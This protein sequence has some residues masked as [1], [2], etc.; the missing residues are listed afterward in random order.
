MNQHNFDP[1]LQALEFLGKYHGRSIN[2]DSA[3][4]GLPTVDG[5][6]TPELFERAAKRSGFTS[7]IANRPLK[8]IH[9]ATLPVVLLLENGE[10]V[11]LLGFKSKRV[12][13]CAVLSA[14]GGTQAIKLKEL[15]KF[16]SG[17]AIFAKPA[18][19][20]EERSEFAPTQ[21][22]KNWFWG[23]LW[24]FR[25]FYG[26]VG[27]ATV[28]IN[29]LALAS[30]LFIMNVYDRVVP[31]QAVDTLYALAIGA[32]AAFVLEFALK[33]LR[34]YLVDRAGHRIDLILGG[35]LFGK[36]LGMKYA[37]KPTS[38]GT[39]A[40]QARSY[41]GLREF[42]TSASISALFDLPFVF[43]FAGVVFVLGG[44]A[45][46]PLFCGA[47]FALVFAALMQVPISRA[48]SSSYAAGNQRQALY[49]EGVTALETIKSTC[50]ESELQAR[51]E[52]SVHVSA[53]ADGK[54]RGF[55]QLALNMTSFTQQIV[56]VGIVVVGFYLVKAEAITMGALIACVIL[57]GR[58]MAPLTMISSTL[59]RFQQSRKSLEG[60]NKLMEMP[61]ER[62]DGQSQFLSLE[63][64][65]AK[66]RAKEV[67][68]SYGPES[69]PILKDVNIEISAGERV[70]LLGQIGCGKSTLLR[71]LIALYHPSKG[72]MDIS[73]IDARQLDPAQLRREVGYLSQDSMLLYGT[74]RSNIAA[75]CP[76]AS[77]TQIWEAIERAGLAEWVRSLPQ[78]VDLPVSEGGKSLSG[79]QRQAIAFA[80]ATMSNPTLLVLDEPT[81]SMDWNSEK[82][83]LR[84]IDDYLE[85]EPGR[86]LIVATHRRSVLSICDRVIVLDSGKVVADG[87]KEQVLKLEGKE[88]KRRSSEHSS[89]SKKRPAYS[90]PPEVSGTEEDEFV[91]LYSSHSPAQNMDPGALQMKSRNQPSAEPTLN[92]YATN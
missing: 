77:D 7:R 79:G 64:F 46:A 37:A 4:H 14:G 9:P 21:P 60:L 10:A 5:R 86:T 55:S 66:L 73:D 90:L 13:E 43:L 20:F 92:P 3:V 51:M 59:G 2:L 40:G 57:S 54:A 80:R 39:L 65:D 1:L 27:V 35:D 36:V 12:V 70:A 91:A 76:W 61:S 72:R 8:K 74:L 30:S 52:D 29:M 63:K 75:G 82:Q 18:Y 15:E 11:V 78:G 81:S 88:E 19:K 67:S 68:F 33:T 34:T 16:Y 69:D 83:L 89:R 87:S 71:M 44:M 58:A 84:R 45:A 6:L 85:E 48:V 31:N 56:T 49:V 47:V 25:G 38:A 17:F 28:M 22:R 50:S 24:R 62:E 23:A 41:E 42:F 26:R 32:A 53:K